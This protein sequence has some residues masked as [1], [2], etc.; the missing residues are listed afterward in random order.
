MAQGLLSTGFASCGKRETLSEL[1]KRTLWTC[2]KMDRLL[3]C[4]KRRQAMF[5]DGD[6]H[7]SL[8]VND[9][10]FLFGQSPQPTTMIIL[11]FSFEVYGSGR[12]FI[13]GSPRAEE[14]SLV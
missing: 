3:S 14:D 10:Q 1:E 12:E 6:M 2:F 5:S 7:F 8:P 9:T 4:G 13:R 11:F